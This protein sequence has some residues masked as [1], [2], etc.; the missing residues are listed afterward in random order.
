MSLREK[1]E[2]IV[3]GTDMDNDVRRGFVSDAVD[4][5]EAYLASIPEDEGEAKGWQPIET[6][7]NP[8]DIVLMAGP[9]SDGEGWW[10]DVGIYRC[11][12]E[13]GHDYRDKYGADSHPTHWHALPVLPTALGISQERKG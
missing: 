9:R 13:A 3:S 4:V 5:A 7:P 12:D 11:K 6:A 8:G 10:R 2:R 1:A